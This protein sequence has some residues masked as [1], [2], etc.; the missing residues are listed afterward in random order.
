MISGGFVFVVF[1]F[2]LDIVFW[3]F[4]ILV[5]REV[6]VLFVVGLGVGEGGNVVFGW[7][8]NILLW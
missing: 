3:F 2:L 1:V 4:N 5:V 8:V 7:L 6:G